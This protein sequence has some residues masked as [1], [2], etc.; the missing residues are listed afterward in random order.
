MDTIEIKRGTT[1]IS[2]I[3]PDESSVQIKRVMAENE[4][5]L[6]F[7]LSYH[8]RF[9]IGDWCTVFGEVYKLNKPIV[10]EKLSVSLYTYTMTMEAY[11]YDLSKIQYLF[12][13]DDNSIKEGDFS[14]VGNADTFVDLVLK[15]LQRI[16][17]TWEKGQVLPST[18]KNLTFSN[19]SCYGVL[20]KLAEAFETEFWIE[21]KKIHLTKRSYLTGWLLRQ[22]RNNGL[23][24]ITQKPVENSGI[25]T[26]IY[27]FGSD[28]NIPSDYRNYSNRLR[29]P[30]PAIY[31]EQ[32][33]DQ[34]GIIEHTEV[35]DDIYPHRTGTITAVD[36]GNIYK[37]KDVNIDFDI[38]AQLLSGV[39]AKITFNT[40]QLSGYVF[41]LS[42]FDNLIKEFT[43]IRSKNETTIEVPSSTI[44]PAIGD[45]YVLTDIR[46]PDTYIN[47]AELALKERAQAFLNI[48]SSP[49]Y[50]YLIS[51]DP[52]F[53]SRKNI[54]P[55][56]GQVINLSDNELEVN[57]PIRI[58]S[59]TRQIVKELI[60]DV[61]LADILNKNTLAL[62]KAGIAGN[63]TNV[64]DLQK[65]YDTNS[66]IN[67]NKCLGD[68]KVEQGTVIGKDIKAA[69]GGTLKFLVIDIDT[70]TIYWQ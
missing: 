7:S 9:L 48:Y 18:Y 30:A 64:G 35:F 45:Q 56:I 65:S 60:F 11:Q 46:M 32:N 20:G 43:I 68:F 26:R 44:K 47:A 29:I 27:A 33:I 63:S 14:L 25:V 24:T 69:T 42:R 13:G 5:R 55:A 61:E 37:F 41:E 36:A 40:G 1:V 3:K 22:G 52:S 34:F 70:G 21:G 19:E 54:I 8:A 38:N 49:N 12:Y 28:K 59:T 15:N 4:I 50:I 51:F 66:L 2:T 16:D 23:Y 53:L 39:T 62:L 10:E 58:I 31:L 6:Q 67:N 17:N 57:K